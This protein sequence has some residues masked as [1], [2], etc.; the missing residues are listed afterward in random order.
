MFS[1][2][3]DSQNG[4]DSIKTV[5]IRLLKQGLELHFIMQSTGLTIDELQKLKAS[6]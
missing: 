5:A 1:Q 2:Y 6:M 3:T 4:E